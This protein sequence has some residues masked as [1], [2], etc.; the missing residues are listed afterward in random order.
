MPK[1]RPRLTTSVAVSLAAVLTL[2]ACG[3]DSD[4]GEDSGGK[5]EASSKSSASDS[6]SSVTLEKPKPEDTKKVDKIKVGKASGENPPK[7]T[8][9]GGKVSVSQATVNVLEEGKGKKIDDGVVDVDLAM[10]TA[11]DGKPLTG[12]NTFEQ[13][14]PQ[15]LDLSGDQVLPGFLKA[16]KGQKVGSSGVAVLPAKDMY[17]KKGFPDGGVG[18]DEDIILYFDVVEET[19]TKADGKKVEPKE[20]LP[21]VEWKDGAPAKF[22][23]TGDAKKAGKTTEV[24]P[25][26]QGDG[27][28]VKKGDMIDVTYTGATLKDGKVFDSSM[29]AGK[30]PVSFPIGEGGVIP[31]WDKGL[32]GQKVGSRVLLVIPAKEAYGSEK[33][34]QEGQPGGDLVFVVDIV[35]TGKAPEAPAGGSAGGQ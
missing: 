7:L 10:Y 15:A 9:P 28:T 17:G 2:G 13:G 25:L 29:K 34:V 30:A 19:P 18:P 4:S 21:E 3:N 24:Q 8:V 32:V 33:E 14:G 12:L 27:K 5:K 26:I 20:G 23:I 22:T 1:A 16:I 31:G 6:P 35:G 11:K